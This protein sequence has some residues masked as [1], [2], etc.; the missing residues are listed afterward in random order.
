[1]EL[2]EPTESPLARFTVRVSISFFKYALAV[3][4]ST[5]LGQLALV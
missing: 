4:G 2:F 5:E 3:S 1:V